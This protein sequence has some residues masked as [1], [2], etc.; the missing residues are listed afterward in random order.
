MIC[1]N[2]VLKKTRKLGKWK[3][4]W[5][6]LHYFLNV[7]VWPLQ[8]QVTLWVF[9]QVLPENCLNCLLHISRPYHHLPIIRYFAPIILK[10][11]FNANSD[12][13]PFL[14]SY[15]RPWAPAKSENQ[16]KWPMASRRQPGI[17]VYLSLSDL[18]SNHHFLVGC[19]VWD[20]KLSSYLKNVQ[21]RTKCGV[22][23][24]NIY[25]VEWAAKA[26]ASTARGILHDIWSISSLKDLVI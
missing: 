7:T 14:K 4:V 16:P 11:H 20:V 5:P 9:P 21:I 1:A 23:A 12:T 10:S 17:S 13:R 15:K 18:G 24:W 25:S 19:W 3:K 6:H 22:K 8:K 26:R 2:V